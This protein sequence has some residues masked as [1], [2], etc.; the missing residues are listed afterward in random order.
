M[1]RWRAALAAGMLTCAL[2]A[3]GSDDESGSSASRGGSDSGGE[4]I[5]VASFGFSANSYFAASLR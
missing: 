3:C 2:A 4:P 1:Q 5:K